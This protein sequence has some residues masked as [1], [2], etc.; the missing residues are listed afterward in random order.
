M[1]LGDSTA[2]RWRPQWA[3][4]RARI[5]ADNALGDAR[6]RFDGTVIPRAIFTD[7]QIGV[8]GLTEAEVKAK[9]HPAVS[10]TT[11]L[12]Y[13][14]RAGAIHKTTGLVKFIAST[15]D[16]RV[17]G[18]HLIGESAS[19]IIQ[20][21]AMALKFKATLADFV[22]LVHVYPTMS[23][24]LKVGAQAFSRDVSKLSCCAE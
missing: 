24:A 10:A 6:R 16:E 11:P 22:D 23:E 13:V 8:V 19:E 2:R 17:L 9:H 7:P 5:V 20:E 15:I 1:S 21:A 12:E 14:P 3:H 18:V 4:D